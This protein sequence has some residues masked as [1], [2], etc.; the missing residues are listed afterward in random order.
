MKNLTKKDLEKIR[1]IKTTLNQLQSQ[2]RDL[3][4]ETVSKLE[5]KRLEKR[6]F[7]YQFV[8]DNWKTCAVSA[9]EVKN[10][11]LMIELEY[12]EFDELMLVNSKYL[13]AYQLY[14]IMNNMIETNLKERI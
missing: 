4:T 13:D 2:L 12:P 10:D 8:D 6:G 3:M 9:M 11:E 1:E 7:S 14:D 5:D